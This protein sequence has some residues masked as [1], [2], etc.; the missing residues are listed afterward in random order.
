MGKDVEDMTT[1]QELWDDMIECNREMGFPDWSEAK[2]TIVRHSFW[3]GGFAML[4]L[5]DNIA[6][7][8]DTDKAKDILK[9]LHEEMTAYHG[10][11]VALRKARNK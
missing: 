11:T 5:L 3:T 7:K 1:F 8:H 6:V 10:T 2:A 9:T 4:A